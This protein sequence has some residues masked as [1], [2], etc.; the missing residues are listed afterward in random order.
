LPPAGQQLTVTGNDNDL[1]FAE[2]LQ[3][4]GAHFR[5]VGRFPIPIPHRASKLKV[6][7][8]DSWSILT[9]L[10]WSILTTLKLR[11]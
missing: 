4:S 7:L 9:T 6:S 2:G 1:T 8:K 5:L 10:D 11:P 3:K